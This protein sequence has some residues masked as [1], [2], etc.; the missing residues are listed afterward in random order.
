MERG[1]YWT[2]TAT[3]ARFD[4]VQ[5]YYSVGRRN[6][7][8]IS[9]ARPRAESGLLFLAGD[10]KAEMQ[11]LSPA[12]QNYFRFCDPRLPRDEFAFRRDWFDSFEVELE[13]P[14][15]SGRAEGHP[16]QR[17]STLNNQRRLATRLAPPRCPR[18]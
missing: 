9:G 8:V 10:E 4:I 7:A 18:L 12:R 17:R 16:E 3:T 5:F 14:V 13:R 1:P 6:T 15:V 2:A 11:A